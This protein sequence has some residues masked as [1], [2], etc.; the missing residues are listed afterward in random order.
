MAQRRIQFPALLVTAVALALFISLPL[1]SVV[2]N[3]FQP[4]TQGV[5]SHLV[6]TVLGEYI[7]NSLVLA[8][9]AGLGAGLLGTGTAWLVAMY[10][11]PGH[12]VLQ[13]TLLL[14]LAMPTYVIA[15]AY[16]DFFQYAGP[17]QSL[18]RESLGW[19]RGDYWFPEIRS[20]Y[21]AIAIFSLVFYP[22]VYVLAR[23]AFLERS[24]TLID[25]ARCLGVTKANA[26]FRV[27]L[28][29]ARPALASRNSERSPTLVCP[30]SPPASTVPGMPSAIP[31]PP[32]SWLQAYWA[33]L[34]L[35]CFSRRQVA[36]EPHS[37]IKAADRQHAQHCPVCAGGLLV[38]A[39]YCL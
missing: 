11:F 6:Q 5:W 16:T 27:A 2:I 28:P 8:L 31:S 9:G 29:L 7:T 23:A 19:S 39:A 25:A 34:H 12:R 35:R 1:I 36:A 32:P 10:R 30:P 20:L 4:D 22:Y 38:S 33:W 14:P 37:T 15:Y 21:G 3:V 17:V 26:F 24:S 13:W 18:L